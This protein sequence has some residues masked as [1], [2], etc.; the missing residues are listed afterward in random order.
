MKTKLKS[1]FEKTGMSKEL[2]GEKVGINV[3][4]VYNLLTQKHAPSVVLAFRIEKV[5][6]GKVTAKDLYNEFKSQTLS[7]TGNKRGSR[8]VSTGVKKSSVR[9][10]H[11]SGK[12]NHICPTHKESLRIRTPSSGGRKKKKPS[13]PNKQSI[14]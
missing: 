3:S 14:R 1:Y 6:N 4:S 13:K 8:Q 12:D 7:T 10:G 11:R 9:P 2:F 5:T